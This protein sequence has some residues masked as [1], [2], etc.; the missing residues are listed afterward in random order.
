VDGLGSIVV[1]YR[2]EFLGLLITLVPLDEVLFA[3]AFRSSGE[4]TYHLKNDCENA[5]IH[6]HGD[7][8]LV[9]LANLRRRWSLSGRDGGIWLFLWK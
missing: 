9:I 4:L 8:H 2:G 1:L 3:Y 5:N 6:A 7:V